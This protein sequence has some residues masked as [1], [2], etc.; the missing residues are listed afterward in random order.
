MP[1][2]GDFMDYITKFLSCFHQLCKKPFFKLAYKS[3]AEAITT[4][5]GL[6]N[7]TSDDGNYW[8][9][10]D[11]TTQKDFIVQTNFCLSE[12]LQDFTIKEVVSL[13]FGVNKD[14]NLWSESV[15]PY[16]FGN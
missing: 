3:G 15:K 8:S 6:I 5:A 10:I 12:V 2:D 11:N 1:A 7:A 9:V 14:F 16:A 4:H 13:M